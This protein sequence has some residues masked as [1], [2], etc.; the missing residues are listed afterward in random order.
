MC[1]I[2][3][4]T[5]VAFLTVG[6]IAGFTGAV[7]GGPSLVLYWQ[8]CVRVRACVLVCFRRPMAA[9][10]ARFAAPSHSHAN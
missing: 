4:Q 1:R 5:I 6:S 3:R 9:A 10:R 8:V 7:I 2:L